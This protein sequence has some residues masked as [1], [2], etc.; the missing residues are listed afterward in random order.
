MARPALNAEK[1]TLPG[2]RLARGV[3]VNNELDGQ[4][5]TSDAPDN[6]TD[7]GALWSSSERLHTGDSNGLGGWED[8]MYCK[9]CGCE[10][11][12]P[13]T[14]RYEPPNVRANLTKGAADEA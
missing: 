13:V 7:C 1:R 12:F 10:M 8:W 3:C 9:A 4:M 2:L 11:F 14:H 5:G 6:C